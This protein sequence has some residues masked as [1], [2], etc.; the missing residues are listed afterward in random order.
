MSRRSQRGALSF[1]ASA[2]R[3]ASALGVHTG[4]GIR[5][6]GLG[7]TDCRV[8]SLLAM[9]ECV[10]DGVPDV[11]FRTA[12]VLPCRGGH[13]CPTWMTAA[14]RRAGPMCPAVPSA[15]RC[16][17]EP[18]TVSLA[19][20]SVSSRGGGVP[21]PRAAPLPTN[22]SRALRPPGI[23]KHTPQKARLAQPHRCAA[24]TDIQYACGDAPRLCTKRALFRC[25]AVLP[26]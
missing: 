25:E 12:P 3:E 19:R 11:P 15:P 18:V 14:P 8:A 7:R 26:K 17:S 23:R 20:E 10:G 13:L 4:A 6:F 22:K 16:H 24:L 5:L 1:R 21:L 2:R 9:T